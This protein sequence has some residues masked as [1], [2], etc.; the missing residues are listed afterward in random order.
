[1]SR[2]SQDHFEHSVP[3]DYTKNIRISIT[4][5]NILP[6]A[7]SRPLVTQK[8]VDSTPL[9][10][11]PELIIETL[12]GLSNHQSNSSEH[13][14]AD[15]TP[16]STIGL[17]AQLSSTSEI[18]TAQ[19]GYQEHCPLQQ[20]SDGSPSQNL[21]QSSDH[22]EPFRK[23]VTTL[24]IS[25]SM[26][27]ELDSDKLSS[28]Q[29]TAA[30][31]YYRGATAEDMLARLQQDE[32]FA[33]INPS[34][35]NQIYLLCG[36]N[37]VGRILHV[38][39]DLRTSMSINSNMF[40]G[41]ELNKAKSDIDNLVAFLHRWAALSSVNII[42]ILPRGSIIRN[43]IINNLNNFIIDLCS[44]YSFTNFISTE[45]NRNLFSTREGYRKNRFFNIKGDDNVHLNSLGVSRLAKH[46]KFLAH[47][48]ERYNY[49][50]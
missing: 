3:K 21:P 25:S 15:H 44:K 30:V 35:V 33:A 42:N 19:E 31:L 17:L 43:R 9:Q 39:R 27:S 2:L 41:R 23:P 29:Q 14:N 47:T 24:Y 12:A 36:T 34:H 6:L 13:L 22:S 50:Y 5:R 45:F 8:T 1:M 46:L 28:D 11:T 32:L 18:V 49:L 38:P 4:L 37:N 48:Q 20:H 26:F 10:S 7:P 40:D 16:C